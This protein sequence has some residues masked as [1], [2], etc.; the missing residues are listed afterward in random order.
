[1]STCRFSDVVIRTTDEK[2][3]NVLDGEVLQW[4]PTPADLKPWVIP[5]DEREARQYEQTVYQG[6]EPT[7]EKVAAFYPPIKYPNAIEYLLDLGEKSPFAPGGE[8]TDSEGWLSFGQGYLYAFGSAG[9]RAICEHFRLTGDLPWLRA[10]TPRLLRAAAWIKKA[11]AT[12]MRLDDAGQ[13]MPY[14]GLIP[15]GEWCDIGEWEHWYFTSA[16]FYR[17]LHDIAEVLRFVDEKEAAD[18]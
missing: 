18:I 15:R 1:M 11:R 5:D 8:Y 7:Y 14:Y 12:T 4:P 9:S 2:K 3:W 10:M 16:F 13:K 17:S 6:Q